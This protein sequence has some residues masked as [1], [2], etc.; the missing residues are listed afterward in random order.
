[1]RRLRLRVMGLALP[2]VISLVTAL[3]NHV[4][5]A[6]PGTGAGNRA[7]GVSV[8]DSANANVTDAA[9]AAAA[10]LTEITRHL[11]AR[12]NVRAQFR[13]TRTLAALK[14]P[15]VST[16]SILFVR[17]HG[18]VWQLATPY[19]ATYVITDAGVS[20]ISPQGQPLVSQGGQGMRGAAQVS[21]MLR[22]ML[23]GDLSAL[24]AQFDVTVQGTASR[25][26]IVLTPNQ[27]QL[28]QS[29]KRLDL[30]GGN[31][32][33]SVRISLANGDLTQMDFTDSV[34]AGVLSAAERTQLGAP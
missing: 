25:W 33:H 22:A 14:Q 3:S 21:R 6:E 11:A 12:G 20:E 32:L 8:A 16:G 30:S 17:E 19:R 2:L 15:L 18:M 34:A 28:A 26:H 13:Q 9:A 24:Y 27:P 1:M 4:R 5:A 10:R 31:D 23:G 29:L 7:S